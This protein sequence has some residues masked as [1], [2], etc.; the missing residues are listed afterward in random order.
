M[1]NKLKLLL[2]LVVVLAV[3]CVG[4]F[5][6]LRPSSDPGG[7]DES[8]Q[9]DIYAKPAV[10]IPIENV[11]SVR[12]INTNGNQ[13]RILVNG[14]IDD[15][16]IEEIPDD[17]PLQTG[18]LSNLVEKIIAAETYSEG[19]PVT[20]SNISELGLDSP[21]AT[22]YV[23]LTDGSEKKVCL[24]SE[25]PKKNGYYLW[26]SDAEYAYV[27]EK[28]YN[29]ILGYEADKFVNMYLVQIDQSSEF[30]IRRLDVIDRTN[31]DNTYA[32]HLKENTGEDTLSL[33]QYEIILPE[34]YDGDD[35]RITEHIF[36]SLTHL[37]ADGVYS[38][39]MSDESLNESGLS[40][41]RYEVVIETADG[42]ERLIFSDIRDDGDYLCIREGRNVVYRVDP[43][44]VRFLGMG[45]SNFVSGIIVLQD[46]YHLNEMD[47][48]YDGKTTKFS[49]STD[50]EG[51]L[52][53][54]MNGEVIDGGSFQKLYRRAVFIRIA[55]D[56]RE[57]DEIGDVI[58][59]LTYVSDAGE[60]NSIDFY[61]VDGRY[62]YYK[63]NGFGRFKVK[64]SDIETFLGGYETVLSG[65]I[66]D[67]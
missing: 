57:Q 61:Y 65:G 67:S 63:L 15:L 37:I 23:E 5:V 66:L 36:N 19:I 11:R 24:G 32:I 62:V 16:R 7:D 40:A 53:A 22:V 54:L 50:D 1:K 45:I 8:S 48:T 4:V 41:P 59:N 49:V 30:K 21:K 44:D 2:G 13:Y 33:Y 64:M 27:V 51:K 42:K 58:L 39:D 28:A 47:V 31:D 52:N 38:Y 25:T 14:S 60:K 20:Q 3:I 29:S 34:Y 26:E 10:S 12:V 18:P 55:S 43:E 35:N 9:P 17:V 46:I 6:A 56:L